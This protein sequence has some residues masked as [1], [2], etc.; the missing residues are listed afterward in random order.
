M[1]EQTDLAA[2]DV[3]ACLP[4]RR[5][6][7]LDYHEEYNKL[8]ERTFPYCNSCGALLRPRQAK[9]TGSWFWGC[10][11]YPDC[12]GSKPWD[13]PEPLTTPT[14]QTD[15]AIAIAHLPNGHVTLSVLAD[16]DLEVWHEADGW[17]TRH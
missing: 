6:C 12:K 9:A 5:N 8:A 11:A 4:P 10:S 13:R 7:G 17:H 3:A 14:A 1:S 15:Q 2:A 16:D